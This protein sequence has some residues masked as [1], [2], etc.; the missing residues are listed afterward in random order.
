MRGWYNNEQSMPMA[1]LRYLLS[2]IIVYD[3]FNVNKY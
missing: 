3:T 1:L 2:P